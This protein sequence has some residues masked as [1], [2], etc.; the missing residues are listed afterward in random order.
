MSGQG[1]CEEGGGDGRGGWGGGQW[2]SAL[3]TVV[4]TIPEFI[5]IQYSWGRSV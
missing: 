2:G 4:F 1:H 5:K 3:H